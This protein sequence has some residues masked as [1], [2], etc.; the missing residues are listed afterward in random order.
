MGRKY[1]RVLVKKKTGPKVGSFII[2]RPDGMKKCSVCKVF[3]PLEEFCRSKIRTDGFSYNCKPC[4]NILSQENYLKNRAKVLKR[5]RAYTIAHPEIQKASAIKYAQNNPERVKESI[6]RNNVKRYSTPKGKLSACMSSRIRESVKKGSKLTRHWEEIVGF[7]I[8]QL[9]KHLEKKFTPE[10]NWGNYGTYWH[11]DHKIPIKAFNYETPE[12]M[13]F[14][15]CWSLKNFQPLE[16]SVNL[17]KQAKIDKAF[18][19]SLLLVA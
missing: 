2:P 9:K 11:I 4:Q 13:D 7:T 19:P 17:K 18:Q 1:I 10:M 15:K 3:K 14:K 6:K 8:D 12:D 16:A 5:T